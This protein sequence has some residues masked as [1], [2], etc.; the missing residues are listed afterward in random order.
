MNKQ[1]LVLDR[2][3]NYEAVIGVEIHVQL[4]TKSKIFCSCPVIAGNQPN[5]HIDVVCS[6]HPGVLPV[7]NERVIEYAIMLGLATNCSIREHS[8]F[9]RKHYYYP[10]LP[11]GYQITQ[12]DKPVCY[13]GIVT[14]NVDDSQK[15]I[16]LTRIHME[17]DAGKNIHSV[18][19][20]MSFV[21]L[22]RAGTPLLEM[23][24][25]PDMSSSHEVRS[26]LKEVHGI[27]TAL[28]ICSGNMEDGAFR[29]DTNISVRKKGETHL[30]TKCELKN[31]NSFKFIFD[32]VEYEVERQIGIMERGEKVVQQTRLW[33]T[34]QKCTVV[35]REKED[36]ADYRYFVDPDLPLV[37][38]SNE[39]IT[40]IQST[41]PELPVEKR[42]RLVKHYG[43][44]D[45]EAG[46]L[47]DEPSYLDY[48]EK[49]YK[50][51]ASPSVL[52]WVLRE[53]VSFCKEK[54]ISPQHCLC[55]P[56]YLAEIIVLLDQGKITARIAQQVFQ[57]SAENG[58]SPAQ[59]IS[60]KKLIVESLSH[61]QLFEIAQNIIQSHSEEVAAYKAGKEKL[62]GFFMGKMMAATKGSIEPTMLQAI[63]KKALQ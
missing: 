24:T 55:I 42:A 6:G 22:N 52:K 7:L 48:F 57:E 26:Y 21:D 13:E 62:F 38:I 30:N 18:K 33:D 58:S 45:Y 32:A 11:K 47:V 59:Y 25:Y 28:G 8:E 44:T 27:V 17:E 41:L 9:A 5:S 49:C 46:I 16:R 1:E 34:K 63:M 3:P 23:V 36:A 14:I 19:G 10:D 35:M 12:N 56:S 15:H 60:E 61:D 39:K 37:H 50:L 54:K 51:A 20:T 29:A 40:L 53:L 43:M 4:Q 31:I 2:Y